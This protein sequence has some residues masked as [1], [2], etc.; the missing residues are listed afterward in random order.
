MSCEGP[1]GIEFDE[2]PPGSIRV[3]R[4]CGEHV[5]V[6]VSRRSTIEELRMQLAERTRVPVEDI[7]LYS[8]PLKKHYILED[9]RTLWEDKEDGY[10][11]VPGHDTTILMWEPLRRTDGTLKYPTKATMTWVDYTSS[12]YNNVVRTS[13]NDSAFSRAMK[14]A[15]RT[16]SA[17]SSSST[18]RGDLGIC[19]TWQPVR[20]SKKDL[21]KCMLGDVL[22]S[23][24]MM[25]IERFYR[26][27]PKGVPSVPIP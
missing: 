16:L 19:G 21:K 25:F 18:L 7:T 15:K 13:T 1:S 20:L 2:A 5:N 14:G 26:P 27:G 24:S 8:A 3:I 23:R 17:F 12:P 11:Y 4:L 9:S 6:I 22:P 10:K